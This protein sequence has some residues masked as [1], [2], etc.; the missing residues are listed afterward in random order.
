MKKQFKKFLLK[1]IGINLLLNQILFKF[2]IKILIK[3]FYVYFE[4]LK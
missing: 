4:Y 1:Q 2:I 3:L